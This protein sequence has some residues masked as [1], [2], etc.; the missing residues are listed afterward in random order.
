MTFYE[1]FKG[2]AIKAKDATV[3]HVQRHKRAYIIGGSIVVGVV[4]IGTGYYVGKQAGAWS[5]KKTNEALN[6]N[7]EALDS[8]TEQLKLVKEQLDRWETLNV[9][10]QHGPKGHSGNVWRRAR[11]GKVF[12]SDRELCDL[13]QIGRKTLREYAN[14]NI[15]H[16]KNE[17]YDFLGRACLM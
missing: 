14:G 6:L 15:P 7:K 12:L 3:E 10:V 17:Q 9:R 16:I 1:D 2:R 4:L 11:D 5:L 13:E 8:T